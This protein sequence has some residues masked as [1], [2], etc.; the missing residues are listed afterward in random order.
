MQAVS[1][2]GRSAR[3]KNGDVWTFGLLISIRSWR[4]WLLLLG[5]SRCL[6]AM[7]A[8]LQDNPSLSFGIA[9][10]ASSIGILVPGGPVGEQALL[11]RLNNTQNA[12]L[13]VGCKRLDDA[14]VR[15]TVHSVFI[16]LLHPGACRLGQVF[17]E[18][19]ALS[20]G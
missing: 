6:S 12:V 1:S 4:V 3:G 2:P 15:G 7:C 18:S 8:V 16:E 14:Y 11:A 20:G 10:A 17:S 19:F 5:R 13:R 9:P